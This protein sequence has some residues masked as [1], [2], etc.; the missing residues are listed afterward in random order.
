MNVSPLQIQHARFSRDVEA[1]L[2][3]H[4]SLRHALVLEITETTLMHDGPA[5]P[6]QMHALHH[7]GALIA[8]DDFGVGYSS[9]GYLQRFPIDILKIDKSFVDNLGSEV[10]NG[11]VLAHAVVSMAHALRLKA[12]AE[13][14]GDQPAQRPAA[15]G[16]RLRPGLSLQ[17]P[18]SSRA[19]RSAP[20]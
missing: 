2:A 12:V 8:I 4:P 20:G 5:V 13:G 9:L 17:P 11:G 14:I 3:A 18:T 16:V 6:E 15:A 1:I 10:G 19:I 7:M